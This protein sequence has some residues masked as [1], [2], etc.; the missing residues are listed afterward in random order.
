[1][2]FAKGP[3]DS[4]AL[5]HFSC[6]ERL[7]ELGLSRLERGRL[8]GTSSEPAST[9]EDVMENAVSLF[10]PMHGRR[11]KDN[12]RKVKWE[13]FNQKIKT[14]FSLRSSAKCWNSSHREVGQSLSLGLCKAKQAGCR[15]NNKTTHEM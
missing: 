4:Q 7:R 10:I 12:G 11:T 3:Q 5:D 15:N 6:E 8:K 2:V 1:M 13:R 14:T 9:N